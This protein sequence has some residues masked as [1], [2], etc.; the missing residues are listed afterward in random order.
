[1]SWSV[2]ELLNY[3]VAKWQSGYGIQWFGSQIET[4]KKL[5]KRNKQSKRSEMI[6]SINFINIRISMR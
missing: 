2:V 5:N 4:T 1:M 6:N 3:L